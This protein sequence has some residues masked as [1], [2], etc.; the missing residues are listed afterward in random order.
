MLSLMQYIYAKTGLYFP[1]NST[2][3]VICDAYHHSE[4]EYVHVVVVLSR[5]VTPWCTSSYTG[6]T[7]V[8]LTGVS[9]F[10]IARFTQNV[11]FTHI[12]SLLIKA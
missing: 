12:F 5:S 11:P 8:R 7:D 10:S 1:M 9:S 3:F 4:K 6:N 2:L